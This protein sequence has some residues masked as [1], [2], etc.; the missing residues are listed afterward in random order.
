MKRMK[1]YLTAFALLFGLGAAS[2]AAQYPDRPVT[3]VV[4][5]SP[6]GAGDTVARTVAT[7]LSQQTGASFVVLNKTGAAGRIGYDYVAKSKPD[8]YTLVA[9]DSS[10]TMYDGLY[11]SLPW[12]TR[13][14]LV[15]IT[16]SAQAPFALI[17]RP[18]AG[19]NDLKT[20]IEKA[21]AD[22]GMLNYGSA[23]VGSANHIATFFFARAAGIDLT[24]IPY[25][26]MGDAMAGL[27]GGS[28]DLMVTA[29]PTALAQHK[30]GKVRVLALS[31]DKRSPSLPEAPTTVESGV[32]YVGS[33]WFGLAAPAGTP[34]AMIDYLNK[35]VAEALKSDEIRNT[36]AGMGLEP[37]GNSVEDFNQTLQKDIDYWARELP[38]TDIRVE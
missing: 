29:L 21:K 14:D 36:L 34:Q 32:E 13:K 26:G 31:S 33:N 37:V 24:H 2:Q 11:Q 19:I 23:G 12:D 38:A 6:G 15:G 7:R 18:E 22:P 9:I 3:I 28:V 1:H 4:P 25:K 35:E 5:F 8:G 10:Y 27:I 20:F 30:G 16:I 17:T